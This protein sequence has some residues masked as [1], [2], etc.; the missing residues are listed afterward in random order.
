M[1]LEDC[2]GLDARGGSVGIVGTKGLTGEVLDRQGWVASGGDVGA[3]LR[4]SSA[5]TND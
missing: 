1:W 4:I 3:L 5:D 2:F